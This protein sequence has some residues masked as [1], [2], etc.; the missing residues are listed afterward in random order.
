M[1]HP[2]LFGPKL[3]SIKGGKLG[4]FGPLKYG[5]FGGLNL[6]HIG[7]FK[8]GNLGG[9]YVDSLLLSPNPESDSTVGAPHETTQWSGLEHNQQVGGPHTVGET[10]QWEPNNQVVGAPHET[11][12][13]QPNQQFVGAGHMTSQWEQ[14]TQMFGAPHEQTQG[15]EQ[16]Q[17]IVGAPNPYEITP[18]TQ[19]HQYEVIGA[20]NPDELKNQFQPDVHFQETVGSRHRGHYHLTEQEHQYEQLVGLEPEVDV[21]SPQKHHHNMDQQQLTEPMSFV[22]LQQEFIGSPNMKQFAAF[23][24]DAQFQETV[25]SGHGH[26]HLTEQQHQYEPL[27]GL[28]QEVDDVGSPQRYH[29]IMEQQTETMPSSEFYDQNMVGLADPLFYNVEM[30]QPKRF[31]AEPSLPEV[32]CSYFL[33]KKKLYKKN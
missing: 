10:S 23:Q 31:E 16:N 26:Y 5:G 9:V 13:F 25:G 24:P 2:S 1:F 3:F 15:L 21:G 12:G 33:K 30:M 11:A 6:G 19:L 22:G 29:H 28:E 18:Q 27:V 7:P 4:G 17:Q 8:Y 20:P 14:N 32:S